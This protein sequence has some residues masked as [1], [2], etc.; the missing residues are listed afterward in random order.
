MA[1]PEGFEPPTYWFVASYSIQTELQGQNG[2]EWRIRT[3][4][5]LLTYICFQDRRIQPDSANS[6]N[7]WLRLESNQWHP[8]LQTGALPTELQ[9]QNG[10][11]RGNRTLP[12]TA[13]KAGDTTRV[14]T[15]NIGAWD[16]I[17]TCV[18]RICSPLPNYSSHP[19]KMV[20]R[21][22]FEPVYLPWKGS[23]LGL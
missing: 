19:S 20:L 23:I 4:G 9:S 6:P 3:F 13:W 2:G 16:R 1:P 8:I 5:R 21:T 17:R 18:E 7:W 22:G 14:L 11:D 12:S 15:R 10:A